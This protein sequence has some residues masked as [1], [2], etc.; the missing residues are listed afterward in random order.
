M[1]GHTPMD[2]RRRSAATVVSIPGLTHQDTSGNYE[3]SAPSAPGPF[4][5]PSR[6]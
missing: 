3:A 5:A 6:V 2:W 1:T 4:R